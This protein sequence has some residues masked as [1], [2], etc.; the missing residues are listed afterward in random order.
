VFGP[1]LQHLHYWERR[2]EQGN[3]A[4]CTYDRK[5]KKVLGREVNSRVNGQGEGVDS[6]MCPSVRRGIVGSAFIQMMRI[7]SNLLYNTHGCSAT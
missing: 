5:C 3:C 1:D 7:I 6:V 2:K 4:W